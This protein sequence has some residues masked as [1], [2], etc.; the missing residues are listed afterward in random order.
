MATSENVARHTGLYGEERVQS[1][2]ARERQW[3][4]RMIWTSVIFGVVLA[5]L[6]NRLM[7]D[8]LVKWLGSLLG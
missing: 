2:H 6:A 4:K 7:L 8:L 3:L 1:A 5:Y